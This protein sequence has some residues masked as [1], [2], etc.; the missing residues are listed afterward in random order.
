MEL[1]QI[2]YFILTA[3]L[4]NMSQAARALGIAQPTLSKSLSNLESELG[5]LLF[6]RTGKKLVLNERGQRFLE[7]AI[8]SM[9]EL[10]NAAAA[11]QDKTVDTLQLGLFC[12]SE[13]FM[14]CVS[15]F[16]KKQPEIGFSISQLDGSPD[17]IDTNKYDALVYPGGTGFRKYR[18]SLAYTERLF[19]AAH[20]N[21]APEES[22]QPPVTNSYEILRLLV[23][24]GSCTGLVPEGSAESFR[25]D[26]NI[27]LTPTGETRDVFIGFKREKHLSDGGRLFLEH[28]SE[29]FSL[30]Y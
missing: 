3:K 9:E 10:E 26:P 1:S 12:V 8:I 24:Y 18:G 19:H 17:K 13:R 14:A 7:G 21:G 20:K 27:V 28:V 2:R 15:G 11:A 22:R 5:V 16:M 25:S 6:D 30:Q 4:Q 29:Y 23:S